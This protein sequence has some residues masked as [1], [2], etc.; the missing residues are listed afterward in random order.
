[1]LTLIF[2]F[3]FLVKVDSILCF[4]A[5]LQYEWFVTVSLY[6]IQFRRIR[7]KLP[8]LKWYIYFAYLFETIPS[9]YITYIHSITPW[10]LIKRCMYISFPETTVVIIPLK[11]DVENRVMKMYIY[12]RIYI[13]IWVMHKNSLNM[14]ICSERRIFEIKYNFRYFYCMAYVF[15]F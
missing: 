2:F 6:W 3:F 8:E 12:A 1:M 9:K 4:F 10:F 13:H 11:K 14:N 7:L 5:L 15:H